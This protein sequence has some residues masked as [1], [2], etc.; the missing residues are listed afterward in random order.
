MKKILFLMF[1]IAATCAAGA[2]CE[3]RWERFKS[4]FNHFDDRAVIFINHSTDSDVCDG[5]MIVITMM[6]DGI[7]IVPL[8]GIILYFHDRKNFKFNFIFFLTILIIGGVVVQVLKYLFNR[9]RPLQRIADIKLLSPAFREH[10]FPSGHT[11]AI[12]TAAVFLSKM[13]KKYSWLFFIVA[14]I[15]GI[16]RIYVGVHFL[17]D[18]IGGAIIGICITEF[19]CW[20]FQVNGKLANTRENAL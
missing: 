14:A 1:F 16:S 5:I 4:S 6:G 7:A 15:V 17:S 3:T 18:V 12:F 19:F 2:R 9:P 20:L 13:I 8:L 10:G 11:M